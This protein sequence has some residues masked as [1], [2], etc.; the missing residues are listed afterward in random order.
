MQKVEGVVM[1][2]P[3]TTLP[4]QA[5]INYGSQFIN[6]TVAIRRE[7]VTTGAVSYG[8][9][10]LVNHASGIQLVLTA[11]HVLDSTSGMRPANKLTVMVGTN[12]LNPDKAI[13]VKNYVHHPTYIVGSGLGTGS[14]IDLALIILESKLVGIGVGMATL[15]AQNNQPLSFAGY[16]QH[17]LS[18]ESL[19][20]K[21]GYLRGFQSMAMN[22]SGL[23]DDTIY[24]SSFTSTLMD[25]TYLGVAAN[26]DSGGGV[27]QNASLHG[28]MVGASPG[29]IIYVD[30]TSEVV[31]NFIDGF[32]AQFQQPEVEISLFSSS[33]ALSFSELFPGREYR[34]MR[35]PTLSGWEE[36]HR[37]TAAA[38]TGSWGEALAAGGSM[39]YKLEWDE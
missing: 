38:S 36:A 20:S 2:A 5:Y 21:D 37:F 27:F 33:I 14:Q 29:T 16:G 17:G 26:G 6:S 9:G 22:P 23:F 8:S 32:V 24:N 28:V 34:V 13:K 10:V 3:G 12:Y 1:L 15:P 7:S 19:Q 11:A 25:S 39:F 18:L 35:S 4:G 30:L 31:T